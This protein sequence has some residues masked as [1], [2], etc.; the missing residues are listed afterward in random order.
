MWRKKLS[1]VDS[2]PWDISSRRTVNVNYRGLLFLINQ[3]L[4]VPVSLKRSQYSR[5]RTENKISVLCLNKFSTVNLFSSSCCCTIND[6]LIH[7]QPTCGITAV[8][9]LCWEKQ[10]HSETLQAVFHLC[11][12]T[13]SQSSC[14]HCSRFN[15]LS[16]HSCTAETA[17]S[18]VHI[19][20]F[21]VFK[22]HNPTS[23][24]LIICN[25]IIF[26]LFLFVSCC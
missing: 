2:L 11:S 10:I 9:S 12:S 7:S 21:P 22:Q 16:G 6:F 13:G 15:P 25:M 5:K 14:L 3:F 1:S 17:A 23:W 8:C 20:L 19:L 18:A 24:K 4:F 26:Q